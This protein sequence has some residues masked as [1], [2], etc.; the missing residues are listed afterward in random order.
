MM[1]I[2]ENSTQVPQSSTTLLNARSARSGQSYHLMYCPPD[3]LVTCSPAVQT[4]GTRREWSGHP[5]ARDAAGFGIVIAVGSSGLSSPPQSTLPT[6]CGGAGAVYFLKIQFMI[7]FIF[8]TLLAHYWWGT[9]FISISVFLYRFTFDYVNS[10][11]KELKINGH[12][13]YVLTE[14]LSRVYSTGS[15]IGQ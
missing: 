5:G 8:T 11:K 3:H 15:F 14:L 13:I 6:P 1:I 4:R 10:R 7:P 12:I 9:S 2:L